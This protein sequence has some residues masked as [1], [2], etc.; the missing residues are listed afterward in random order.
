MET[1]SRIKQIV[2]TKQKIKDALIFLLNKK[3]FEQITVT[4]LCRTAG[5]SR[6][7]FYTYY[8]DKYAFLDD[9]FCDIRSAVIADFDR[10]Q[11]YDNSPDNPI[12]CWCNLLDAILDLYEIYDKFLS[13]VESDSDSY[14]YFCYH[15]HIL[16]DIEQ[17]TLKYCSVMKP[18]YS[19]KKTS[20]LLC[21][22]L[23]GF[24]RISRQ[25]HCSLV[26]IRRETKDSLRLLLKSGLFPSIQDN[27]YFQ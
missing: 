5:T 12:Q 25:E 27:Q 20:S 18:K 9:F 11:L 13:H 23:W 21:N 22:G 19:V 1:G 6:I 26:Q 7:T 14:L 10:R 16:K 17:F 3:K 2:R 24:I 4:E 15:W 8:E